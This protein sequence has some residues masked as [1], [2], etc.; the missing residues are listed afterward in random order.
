V[1]YIKLS[2]LF[3]STWFL[4]TG[5]FPTFVLLTGVFEL[6]FAGAEG[7]YVASVIKPGV[8]G[9]AKPGVPTAGLAPSGYF[10]P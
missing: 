9:V 3:L 8:K 6:G 2:A 7:P 4:F 10:S 1:S 5:V